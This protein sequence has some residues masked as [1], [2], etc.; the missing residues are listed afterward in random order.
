MDAV[1]IKGDT[2]QFSL[3]WKETLPQLSAFRLR[4]AE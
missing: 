2:V 3:A 4:F 1:C